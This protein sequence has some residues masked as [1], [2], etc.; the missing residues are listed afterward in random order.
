MA[1]TA[2]PVFFGIGSN[3]GDR[4][5]YLLDA[6][7]SLRNRFGPLSVASFYETLP[8]D[9]EDQP[10]FVNTVASAAT[11]CSP[12]DLL[13]AV[14]AIEQSFGRVRN[15]RRGPRTVDIDILL[16]GSEIIHEEDLTVPHPRMTERKFVLVP[17]LEL[18]PTLR[19][20]S[21]G[22]P[23]QSY[24]EELPPQGIYYF[25]STSYSPSG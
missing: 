16:V 17:L 20:P 15:R 1:V 12:H 18:D 4:A 5:S 11:A 6:L 8:R 13:S 21:T 2:R 24:L 9:V 19:H 23:F 7:E 14:A 3:L 10:P 25:P 22:R